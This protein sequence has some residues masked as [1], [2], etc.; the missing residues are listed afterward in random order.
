MNTVSIDFQPFVDWDNSPF[1][2]FDPQGKILYLNNSAEILFGYVSKKELYDLALAYAPQSFG[3][4][5]TPLSLSY[6][7]F[8][9]YAITVGYENEEQ[10]SIRFY[11][12]P[13]TKTSTPIERD[14][15]ATT[16]INLLLEANI[17]LFK[18]KNSNNLQL[19]TDPDIPQLKID[20][21]RFSKLLR[22]V[23]ESFRASDSIRIT[24]KLLVGEHVII[25]EKKVLIAQ[26]T[27]EANGRYSDSDEEIKQLSDQCHISCSLH[28]YNI[29]LEI[30][31]IQ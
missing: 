2:L 18:T 26:L 17:A 3:Y 27:V 14:K 28:K 5:T 9:F 6:D 10:L 15:L 19:L 1:I 24:L 29:K 16:D 20:Q 7:T 25:E 4:K 11:H 23:L 31:L 22:K 12:A 30:P 21:N 13:R 8:S